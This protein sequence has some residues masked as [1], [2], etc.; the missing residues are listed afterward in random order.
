MDKHQLSTPIWIKSSYSHDDGGNCVEVALTWMK[1][2]YSD[3]DGGD[4]IEVAPGTPD[5]VPVR[6]SKDPQG[7]VLVFPTGGWTS[8][9][10]ALK[11]GEF[12]AAA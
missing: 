9:V 4:C 10:A 1:S 11:N 7:P 5:A 12:P 3:R 2:S 8:F 6:D